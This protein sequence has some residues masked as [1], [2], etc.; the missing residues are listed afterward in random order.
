[1]YQPFF[2]S[3]SESKFEFDYS[4]GVDKIKR[5]H[6]EIRLFEFK[7][8]ALL[9][10]ID[11]IFCCRCCRKPALIQPWNVEIENSEGEF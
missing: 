10:L 6:K 5:V 3:L 4:M 7:L 8:F 9:L 1:M 2:W 11:K